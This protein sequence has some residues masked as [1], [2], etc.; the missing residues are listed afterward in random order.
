MATEAALAAVLARIDAGRVRALT[1]AAVDVYSPTYAEEPATEVFAR[2]LEQHGLS[3]TR[4]AVANPQGTAPRHNLLV[5]IGPEPL[6][7]LLVGHVDTIASGPGAM[8]FHRAQVAGDVLTGLGSADM[9]G[10]CAAQVEAF[11]ALAASGIAL[12][13]GVGLALVVGEEEYGDGSA[14]LPVEFTAPLCLV[15]EPTSLEPCI[16]HFGYAECHLTASGTRAHAALSG[17]GGSAIHAMLTW[18]LAVLDGMP[19]SDPAGI[20]AAN[21]RLIRGGDTLFVVADSC[22]ALL[23][24]HWAPGVDPAEVLRRIENSREAAQWGHPACQLASETLFQAA[25]FANSEDDPRLAPLRAAFQQQDRDWQAGV[26]PSHSDAGL[27]V[28]RGSMTIVCGPGALS[29]AHAPGESV[30][31]SEVEAAARLYASVAVLACGATRDP[32]AR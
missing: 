29:A 27:F 21:A 25:A 7:L 30:A 9:K 14:A 19:G 8:A 15:G 6:G 18:L 4:Q 3:V 5:R 17:G 23:D 13:R 16:S 24:L 32:A 31:L 22:D 1:V 2:S 11:L 10:G 20:I 26:F 28:D 12:Q